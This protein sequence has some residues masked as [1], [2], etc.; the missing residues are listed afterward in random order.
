MSILHQGIVVEV[1]SPSV[2]RAFTCVRA[3]ILSRTGSA[4]ILRIASKLTASPGGGAGV[5]SECARYDRRLDVH[6]DLL[7]DEKRGTLSRNSIDHLKN[8]GIYAFGAI[9]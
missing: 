7:A 1:F 4:S 2:R 3:T 5:L 8:A 9:A 6:V